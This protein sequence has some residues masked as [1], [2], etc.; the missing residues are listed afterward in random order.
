MDIFSQLDCLFNI[1]DYNIYSR[2][3]VI[4]KSDTRIYLSRKELMDS[5]S[6]WKK[7]DN[8]VSTS[9]DIEYTCSSFMYYLYRI[10]WSMDKK[11]FSNSAK[12]FIIFNDKAP[13]YKNYVDCKEKYLS[14]IQYY[15]MDL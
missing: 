6:K 9:Y 8:Y 7:L 15:G 10:V 2:F 3:V 4:D 1:D 12:N 5:M 13:S 11:L 14:E